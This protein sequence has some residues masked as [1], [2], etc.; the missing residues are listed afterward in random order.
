M[1]Y[2]LIVALLFVAIG[3]EKDVKEA[4]SPR[5]IEMAMSHAD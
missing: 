5:T 3:C 1:R 4:K 2:L